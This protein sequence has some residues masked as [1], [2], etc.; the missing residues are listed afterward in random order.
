[1][2]AVRIFLGLG[3]EFPAPTLDI[4]GLRPDIS[5]LSGSGQIY[6]GRGGLLLPRQFHNPPHVPLFVSPSW[7]AS[8][9]PHL[10]EALRPRIFLALGQICIPSAWGSILSACF[11]PWTLVMCSIF[12]SRTKSIS[13]FLAVLECFFYF[14]LVETL[15]LA[16]TSHSLAAIHV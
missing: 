11:P 9:N 16:C 2:I 6:M 5:G 14:P 12:E 8:I 10:P 15:A 7:F 4:S 3:P 1:M 13:L